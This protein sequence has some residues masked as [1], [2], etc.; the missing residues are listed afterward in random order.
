MVKLLIVQILER[1]KRDLGRG[2]FDLARWIKENFALA[3]FGTD[4]T[5][6]VRQNTRSMA[7]TTSSVPF[8]QKRN[9]DLTNLNVTSINMSSFN[10]TVTPLLNINSTLINN[11]STAPDSTKK[12]TNRLIEIFVNYSVV[13]IQRN[14]TSA[15]I[16]ATM[17]GISNF[18]NIN[19]TDAAKFNYNDSTLVLNTNLSAVNLTNPAKNMSEF[20]KD[21]EYLAGNFTQMEFNATD[22]TPLLIDG[23]STLSTNATNYTF[24]NRNKSD[25]NTTFNPQTTRLF[26]NMSI[27]VTPTYTNSTQVLTNTTNVTLQVQN[28]T[29]TA[30]P[31]SI[32]QVNITNGTSAF[33]TTAYSSSISDVATAR[34]ITDFK[35][36]A[37]P[38]IQRNNSYPANSTTNILDTTL[39]F[40]ETETAEYGSSKPS[41]SSNQLSTT[42]FVYTETT[43]IT[44]VDGSEV[45]SKNFTTINSTIQS[46]QMTRGQNESFVGNLIT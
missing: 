4:L 18:L 19:V 17:R 39:V 14:T 43:T 44:Y 9:A 16:N 37:V 21:Y 1:E 35:T 41:T 29:S 34:T 2:N 28:T 45:N 6:P 26:T 5:M 38:F 24:I 3:L 32:T 15:D 23:S 27:T 25:E 31:S 36:L 13:Y 33:L 7:R 42:S 11:V 22:Q 10:T 30:L 12:N 8:D 40:N 20:F 46:I